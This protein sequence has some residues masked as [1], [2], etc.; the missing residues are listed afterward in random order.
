MS[1]S[2]FLQA[3][4]WLVFLR[5]G[6]TGA[7]DDSLRLQMGYPL[8]TWILWNEQVLS[9]FTEEFF[10]PNFFFLVASRDVWE[11]RSPKYPSQHRDCSQVGSSWRKPNPAVS[12]TWQEEGE[13]AGRKRI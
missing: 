13:K 2:A 12:C 10:F 1:K 8:T 11:M 9:I 7:L 3:Y 4:S 5:F 6:V